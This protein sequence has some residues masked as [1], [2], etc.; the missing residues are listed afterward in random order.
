MQVR[1]WGPEFGFRVEGVSGSGTLAASLSS[2]FLSSSTSMSGHSFARMLVL[3]SLLLRVSS[4]VFLL[5]CFPGLFVFVALLDGSRLRPIW[6][7]GWASWSRCGPKP[8]VFV[9]FLSSSYPP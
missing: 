3:V 5:V 9:N 7:H 2:L 8:L 1:A 4:F 6:V